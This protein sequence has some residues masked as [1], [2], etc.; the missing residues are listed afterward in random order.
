MDTVGTRG[1]R[2]V[3]AVVYQDFRSV[4]CRRSAHRLNDRFKELGQQP[5]G[6]L[7]L[8]DLHERHARRGC[9]GNG[10]NYLAFL[11][12]KVLINRFAPG[13]QIEERRRRGEPVHGLSLRFWPWSILTLWSKWAT[14]QN[15]ITM[16]STPR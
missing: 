10:L 8:A 3:G 14:S 2:D 9:Y 13:D 4:S 15:A 12:C 11:F 1:E 7:L 16:L 6:K 5:C